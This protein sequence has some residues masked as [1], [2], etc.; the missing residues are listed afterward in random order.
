MFRNPATPA[1]LKALALGGIAGPAAFIG[2]WVT[3][4]AR[5]AGYSPVN[6][7][8]SRLAAVNAPTRML[9]TSGFVG[10][11]VGVGAF[12]IALRQHL[13]GRAWIGALTTAIATLG[14]AALPLGYSSTVDLLH[15]VA[16][17]IGY[18]SLAATPFLAAPALRAQGLGKIAM[19]SRGVAAIS[20][21]CLAATTLGP[22]HGLLQRTGLTVS[23]IWIVVA[24]IAI[25]SGRLHDQ[26]V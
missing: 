2:A 13:K 9:M 21:A 5:T 12:S 10:F 22:A 11:T 4:A 15:G 16:A 1:Q 3:S 25:A 6:T 7:A 20:I 18:L 17:S 8:I 14:V 23:D 24:A 26:S 19:V